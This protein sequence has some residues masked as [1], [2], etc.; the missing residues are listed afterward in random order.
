MNIRQL[1]I[2]KSVCD[3]MSFTKAAEKLY[4]TQPA[5]SRAICE[6]EDGINCRL[7]DRL[8][9]KIYLTGPG[10]MFLAKVVRILELYD[11]LE[12]NFYAA[13]DKC[14]VRIGSSI[15][16]GSFWLPAIVERFQQSCP[17][18]PLSVYIDRAADVEAKLLTN[19]IDIGLIE[20][21]VTDENLV[22]ITFAAYEIK[23][24]C[25]SKHMFAKRESITIEELISS[26]LI[27]RERGSAI[28]DTFDSALRLKGL[29]GSPAWTGINSQALIQA[30]KRNLG[31]T[32]MPKILTERE[33]KEGELVFV[34][35]EGLELVN[36]N[37]VAYQKDKYL[38]SSMKKFIEAV[39]IE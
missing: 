19:E 34:D 7:F 37:Y 17:D 20:G 39:K 9:H 12:D 15:T 29:Q 22:N 10:S 21:S 33:V 6:L 30:V 28:R 32:V 18:A 26:N 1:K 16:I 24:V 31:V 3:E 4:M 11:D 36:K 8:A 14:P 38:T 27:L 25:S 5:V 23:V 13:E 2:F 35:V